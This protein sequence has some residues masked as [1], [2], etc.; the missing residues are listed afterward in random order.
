MN[1]LMLSLPA[2]AIYVNS[3]V[4]LDLK[5]PFCCIHSDF[6]KFAFTS[7]HADG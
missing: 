3:H 5:L 7:A 4:A 6:K 1:G 2:K